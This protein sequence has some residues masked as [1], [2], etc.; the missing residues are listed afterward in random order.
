MGLLARILVEARAGRT[1]PLGAA[2]P[3]VRC[4]FVSKAINGALRAL[5]MSTVHSA[6]EVQGWR[7]LGE[8]EIVRL[9]DLYGPRI[10]NHLNTPDADERND[11]CRLPGLPRLRSLS[12]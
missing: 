3:L 7:V 12:S 1:Q 5:T 9:D 6:F 11:F 2:T 4:K 10:A 8:D